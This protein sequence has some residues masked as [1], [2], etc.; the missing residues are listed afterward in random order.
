MKNKII[1]TYI[2]GAFIIYGCHSGIHKYNEINSYANIFPDYI[3]VVIPPNIS[4]L[5]FYINDTAQK[6]HIEIYSKNGRKIIIHQKD[7]SI[8]IPIHKWRKLLDN[9]KGNLLYVD[10]FIKKDKWY[11]FKTIKDSIVEEK[12]ESYLVYRLINQVNILWREMGIYQRDIENFDETPIYR[13]KTNAY[14]CVNCHHFNNAQADYMTLHF[15]KEN[16]GTIIKAGDYIEKFDTKTPYTMSAFSYPAW[17]PSGKYIAYVVNKVT[18]IFTS[19]INFHEVVFDQASD[20]VVYDIK[21]NTVTTSPKVSSKN[22]ENIPAFSH[23]GKWLYY[24]SGPPY[25]DDSTKV[26]VKFDLVR[27]SFD[28]ETKTWGEPDTLLTSRET[29]KSISFPRVS[30]DDRYI[31]VTMS[32]YSYFPIFDKSSDLYIFDLK[33]RKYYPLECNSVYTESYHTWSQTG[34]WFVFSSRRIDDCYNRP[35]FSYFDKNGKSHKPFVLPQKDPLFYKKIMK[36]YN[37]PELVSNR[38][39]LN[40]NFMRDFVKTTPKKVE[41]DTTVDIDA[42]SGATFIYK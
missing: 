24:I 19:D 11:K 41:F 29:G 5:N 10:I 6:Y 7:P 8:K 31:M 36:N 38:V 25:T 15:R 28:P 42:L 3:D 2:I 9:N 33:T 40:E 16:P 12:I 32:S 35:F 22:R 17:H 30:P 39:K 14:G 23:D 26:F 18:Q 20:L 37:L 27:I 1:L 13:N 4:P 34:R 21:K